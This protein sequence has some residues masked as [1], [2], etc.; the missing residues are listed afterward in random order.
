V[1]NETAFMDQL[2]ASNIK[3]LRLVLVHCLFDT[4]CDFL[5]KELEG[6]VKQVS[7]IKISIV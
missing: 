1:E 5:I 3:I 2:F 6:A 4:N 7:T